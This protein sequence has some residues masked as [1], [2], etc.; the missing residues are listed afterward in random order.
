MTD[1]SGTTYSRH[2]TVRAYETDPH[3]RL[4]ILSVCNML[5]DTAGEHAHTLGLGIHD[6]V[7]HTWVLSR[8]SVRMNRFPSWAEGMSIATWPS[9]ANRLIAHRDF[10]LTAEDGAIVGRASSAWVIVDLTT[11]R[12]VNNTS[13]IEHIP[14]P[15]R[16]GVGLDTSSKPV[17][18]DDNACEST[19]T[20]RYGELD[21]NRHVNNVSYI[22]WCIDSVPQRTLED[23]TCTGLD[24]A[25]MGEAQLGTTVITRSA[26]D[27]TG[28]SQFRHEIVREGEDKP[29]AR[30]TTLWESME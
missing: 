6:L 20:V 8:L 16:E 17:P 15:F 18:P 23:R 28:D 7:D 13:F 12:P 19:Y 10:L 26:P 29:L 5:Q 9:G 1:D 25:F 21:I 2:Y 11:R 30:C 14:R 24:I 22:G 4:A 27:T 3:G